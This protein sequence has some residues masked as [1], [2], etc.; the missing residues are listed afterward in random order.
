[1]RS[2]LLKVETTTVGGGTTTA[3][4]AK[5]YPFNVISYLRVKQPNG[6]TMY[7]VSNGHHGAMIQKYRGGP[8]SARPD[9]PAPPPCIPHGGPHPTTPLRV[10]PPLRPSPPQPAPPA[11]SQ[12]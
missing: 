12:C 5:D 8:P 6:Q 4:G 7:S 11:R 3:V 1:M 2:I 9:P 10:P